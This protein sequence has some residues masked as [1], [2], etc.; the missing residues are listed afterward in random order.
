MNRSTRVPGMALLAATIVLAVVLPV[1]SFR[2]SRALAE[3]QQIYLRDRASRIADRLER[4]PP[5]QL[6]EPWVLDAL[7]RQEPGLIGL[8]CFQEK[9]FDGSA[10]LEAIWTGREL[11]RAELTTSGGRRIFR[12]WM[13]FESARGPR[14]ARVDMDL[15]GADFLMRH[16]RRNIVVAL[17]SGA[18]LMMLG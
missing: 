9:E 2:T 4:L 14:I 16:A 3:M 11:S 13:P 10:A 12:A 6:S 18:T 15:T 5:E 7:R 8:R 1:Y 17:F